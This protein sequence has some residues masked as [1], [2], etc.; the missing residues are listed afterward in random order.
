MI[1]EA[2]MFRPSVRGN[3]WE[4]LKI[5]FPLILSSAGYAVNL[6]VDRLMLQHYSEY[7]MA[8]AFPAGLTNF[9]MICFFAGMVGYANSFV[10]QYAGAGMHQRIGAAVW[11]AVYMALLGAIFAASMYFPAPALFDFFGHA[12]H[13]R[14]MEVTYFRILAL[15]DAIPL[16]TFAFFAFWGGRGKTNMVM[17]VDLLI[18][19]CNIPFNYVLIFGF[20]FHFFRIPSLGVSG[21]AYGTLAAGMIGLLVMIVCFFLIRRNREYFQTCRAKIDRDLFVRLFRYGAPNGVQQFLDLASF[22][23]FVILL[24]KLGPHVLNASGVVFSLNMLAMIPMFGLGQTV[25]ILVGQGIGSKNIPYAEQAVKSARFCLYLVLIVVGAL[26][27]IHPAPAL[28]SFLLE[29][30]T[31]SYDLAK[32]MLRFITAYMLFD[33]TGILYGSAIKGAGDTK[34]SMWIGASFAWGLYGFPCLFVFYFFSRPAVTE[35]LGS[36]LAS[37]ITLWTLWGICVFYIMALGIVF[38]LR[39]RTGKWKTM[40]VIENSPA[41][42]PLG[43]VPEEPGEGVYIS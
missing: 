6:F 9:A 31:R 24:G 19:M 5:A 3:I 25:S 43:V 2:G 33:A 40:K 38:Y 8:A 23:A 4:V 28:M 42:C 37:S 26:Y 30:G 32:I 41:G 27:L 11:Q 39:Y 35:K 29:P 14:P 10:A 21:A 13:L 36:A 12:E 16:L 34:F 22:N 18:T 20:D 7:A 15:G 1:V 17:M